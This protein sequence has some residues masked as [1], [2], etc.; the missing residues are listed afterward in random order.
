MEDNTIDECARRM[1]CTTQTVENRIKTLAQRGIIIQVRRDPVDKRR[2]LIAEADLQRIADA[3]QD[4]LLPARLR[5]QQEELADREVALEVAG[6]DGLGT[7][8]RLCM[9]LEGMKLEYQRELDL[10]RQSRE[11]SE[12]Q[13]HALIE[14]AQTWLA[15]M[16]LS[17]SGSAER[18]CSL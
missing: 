6:S 18:D 16:K 8:E 12:H 5:V 2:R 17:S 1:K 13:M 7:V 15:E 10:L 14:E 4:A 9:E 3:Y 11:R